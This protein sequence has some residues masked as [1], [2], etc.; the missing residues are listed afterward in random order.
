MKRARLTRARCTHPG[1]VGVEVA[2]ELKAAQ[3]GTRVVLVH[4]HTALL[5]SEPL[6][7]EYRTVTL[8][9][10]RET[11]TEVVLGRRV[12][13]TSQVTAEDGNTAYEVEFQDGGPKMLVSEVIWAVSRPRP[14]TS[15]LEPELLDE[16]HYV[17]VKPK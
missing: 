7:D 9:L 2:A 6:P 15:F 12:S 16:E 11:G 3:P 5:S 8:Q 4:S 1:A 14:S 17:K 10:V 13:K